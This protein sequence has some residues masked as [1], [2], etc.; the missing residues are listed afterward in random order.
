MKM[1]IYAWSRLNYINKVQ[2]LL[3]FILSSKKYLN[4][5]YGYSA[6]CKNEKNILPGLY[7]WHALAAMFI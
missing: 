7:L 1:G 5:L 2:G 3:H 4:I 6:L